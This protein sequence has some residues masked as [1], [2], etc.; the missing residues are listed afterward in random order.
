MS[1]GEASIRPAQAEDLDELVEL[2]GA[3]CDALAAGVNYS[4]WSR[5]RYPT[6]ETAEKWLAQGVLHVLCIGGDIAA[7][8]ALPPGD[9]PGYERADWSVAATG[10]EVIS[11][12]TVVTH[13]AY[14]RHGLADELMRFAIRRGG[15]LGARTL[16]L[17]VCAFNT[18][19][20]PVYEK[21]GFR[22]VSTYDLFHSRPPYDLY[23]LYE[24]VY[25]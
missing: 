21:A 13:P 16:R 4:G 1:G 8:I 10:G 7:S 17:D 11:V 6:R 23:H 25:R 2:Y 12:H 9:S 24:Y 14:Q 5:G 15:E 20:I 18:P 19:A 22:R 3:V